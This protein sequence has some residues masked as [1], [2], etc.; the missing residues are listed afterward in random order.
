MSM[1]YRDLVQRL[2]AAAVSLG[3]LW[4]FALLLVTRHAYNL[5]PILF[6]LASVWLI[7]SCRRHPLPT[8]AWPL[9]L[10]FLGYPL[11][12]ALSMVMTG[13]PLSTVDN[14]ARLLLLV[15]V[16]WGLW[17][18]PLRLEA[19]WLGAS[20]GALGGLGLALY[21]RFILGLPRAEGFQHPIMFGDVAMLL[22]LL[23]LVGL[24]HGLHDRRPAWLLALCLLGAL[25][26]LMTSLLS[27]T[28]GGWI[29]LPI[30]LLALY[31]YYAALLPRRLWLASLAALVLTA[32]M[33]Y[34]IPAT[35]VAARIQQAIHEVQGFTEPTGAA[36]SVGARLELWRAGL[37][38]IPEAGL[39]GLSEAQV[40]A[41]LR[42]RVEQ[43]LLR[44]P[45]LGQAHF[46][47][48][49]IEHWVRHGLLGLVALLMLY[50]LPLY[51]FMGAAHATD[52][53]LKAAAVAGVVTLTA[54]IDFG[55]TQKFFGHQI[56][57]MAFGFT[58]TVVGAVMLRLQAASTRSRCLASSSQP[59][60]ISPACS[61]VSTASSGIRPMRMKS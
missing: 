15:L 39:F 14:P 49:V 45:V 56:G 11:A 53:V 41:R 6:L 32:L 27:G 3:V 22:G 44:P 37:M 47:N 13:A 38:L 50:V 34:H 26:G 48:E 23:A 52:P 55:L 8:T 10:P 21:Q 51:A 25:S 19:I 61:A 33:A 2:G 17:R 20:L 28:R 36:S 57:I 43:G 5:A 40:E 59:G 58:I 30:V 16:L 31:R 54:T 18:W 12:L 7:L 24:A 60:T 42:T 46:H 29:G 35:G 1:P 4:F 9:V